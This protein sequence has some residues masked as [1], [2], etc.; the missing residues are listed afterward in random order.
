MIF[1]KHIP[2]IEKTINYSFKDKSLLMQAFTRTSFC[3]EHKRE[4]YMSSEVLEFFG[5]S[6]L[7][8]AIITL[9]LEKKT[10]RYIHGIKTDWNEG[11]F[12]NLRSK[13][14]DKRNLSRSMQALGLQ[15]YLIMGEGDEK[16][17]VQNEPSVM[18]DLFESIIGAIYIDC[19]MNIRTVIA[20][21]EKMLDVNAYQGTV[22]PPIQSYKNSLQEWCADKKRRLPPP[23]YRTISESGPDHKKSYKRGCYINDKLIGTG[24][25]KNQKL[26]DTEA[27]KSALE[28]LMKEDEAKNAPTPDMQIKLR[29]L[30]A[31]EKQP[32]PEWRDLGETENSTVST[33]EF[34]IEC[35]ALGKTAV[36]KGRSKQEARSAAAK[37]IL[38]SVMSKNKQIAPKKPT[39]TKNTSY[40]KLKTPVPKT[41]DTK[42]P[43][44]KQQL[45]E[46]S[47]LKES[48]APKKRP[49]WQKKHL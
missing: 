8:T 17:D 40:P 34:A 44:L 42:A 39:L 20:S 27:A 12:S 49:A 11:D 45:P 46:K 48:H 16:T 4:D 30:C 2:E 10:K 47:G 24:E 13:L 7:S 29:E 32:T 9:L 15:K 41:T 23:V 18:E 38:D 33:P 19:G 22:E 36:G 14:S 26:A 6:V 3:N 37:Q 25:G 1:K 35:R 5:D 43:R 28:A 21:V 31:K